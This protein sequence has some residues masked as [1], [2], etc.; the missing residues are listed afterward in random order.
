[1]HGKSITGQTRT[2]VNNN[3][4]DDDNDNNSNKTIKRQ[5]WDTYGCF[6]HRYKVRGRRHD[7]QPIGSTP[8]LSVCL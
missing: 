2:S 8:T 4:N 5:T 7:L 3:N 1:M 6:G